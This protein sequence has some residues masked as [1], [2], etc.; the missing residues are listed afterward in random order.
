MATIAMSDAERR[1]RRNDCIDHVRNMWAAYEWPDGAT[2][3]ITYVRWVPQRR[4]DQDG[5]W[6]TVMNKDGDDQVPQLRRGFVTEHV[7]LD[8]PPEDIA[9]TAWEVLEENLDTDVYVNV[10][11]RHLQVSMNGK[12]E[13]GDEHQIH[14]LP[15]LTIDL[16]LQGG[17]HAATT[18]LTEDQAYQLIDAY[19]V[20]EATL[21][22][23]SG[24]GLHV[25]WAS[26]E[27]LESSRSDDMTL[28]DRH[29]QWWL[30][31]QQTVGVEKSIDKQGPASML[32]LAGSI[33]HKKA[34]PNNPVPGETPDVELIEVN[35]KAIYN[36]DELD[37]ALP[38]LREPP[39]PEVSQTAR[40]EVGQR[41]SGIDKTTSPLDRMKQRIPAG[42][43]L[44]HAYGWDYLETDKQVRMVAPIPSADYNSPE[45]SQARVFQDGDG[46]ERVQVFSSTAAQS[47]ALTPNSKGNVVADSVTVAGRASCGGDFT[48]LSRI[49]LQHE[50][51][52]AALYSALRSHETPA[53]LASAYPKRV[54][55]SKRQGSAHRNNDELTVVADRSTDRER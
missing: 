7:E 48:L 23:H 51:E 4:A 43:L 44:H 45:P 41:F 30:D 12:N 6:H 36:R 27:T 31:A 46:V 26:E 15:A 33:N 17:K 39:K 29:N 2:L 25:W 34:N 14:G 35:A 10:A 8:Q 18:L 21:I 55:W 32:R 22:I 52:P 50:N 28:L 24:G 49:Y 40:R 53:A 5:R 42:D 37:A 47:L 16:D 11:P 20:G 3:A 19:P 38:E 13:R 54:P 9:N 1:R